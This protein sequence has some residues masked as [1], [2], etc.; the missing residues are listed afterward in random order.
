MRSN[1]GAL[2]VRLDETARVELSALAEPPGVY[3][4]TRAA[5][6]WN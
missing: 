1:V 6:P 5:L 2:D 3:W 4:Q